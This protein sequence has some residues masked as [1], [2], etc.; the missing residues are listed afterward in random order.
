MY[1]TLYAQYPPD[2]RK[3]REIYAAY[4]GAVAGE[5]VSVEECEAVQKI[6]AALDP[7]ILPH[8]REVLRGLSRLRGSQVQLLTE[9]TVAYRGG[10]GERTAACKFG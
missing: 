9:R 1:L 4:G 7:T 6:L 5:W 2:R 8:A 3:E 10:A